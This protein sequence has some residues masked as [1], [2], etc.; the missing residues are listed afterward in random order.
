MDL[1]LHGRTPIVCGASSGLGRAC[2]HALAAEGVRVVIN[3]RSSEQLM[4]AAQVIES[5]TRVAI[6]VIAGDIVSE[7]VRGLI[8]EA[9][10]NP[11]ILINNAGGPPAGD[12]RDWGRADWIKALDMSML[13]SIALTRAVLDGMVARG[14]GR[15]VNITSAGVKSPGSYPSLGLSIG[16]RAGLTGFMGTLARQVANSNVTINSLLPGRFDTARL[17]SL[18]REQAHKENRTADQISAEQLRQIPA[19]RFGTADEFGK[20]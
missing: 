19:R 4:K 12:F 11:D 5:D 2:A 20:L 13:T 14:F 10:P 3:A 7:A 16:A 1:G 18:N 17:R 6:R 15:I 8:L 9:C